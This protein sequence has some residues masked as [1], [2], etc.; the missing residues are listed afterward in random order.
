[1]KSRLASYEVRNFRQSLSASYFQIFSSALCSQTPSVDL[2]QDEKRRGKYG[3]KKGK[4]KEKNLGRKVGRKER[5]EKKKNED[6]K[7]I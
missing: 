2:S 3:N 1:V 5:C 4:K 6:R 7:K